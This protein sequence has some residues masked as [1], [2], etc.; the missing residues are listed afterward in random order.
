M[1]PAERR[2]SHATTCR[3]IGSALAGIALAIEPGPALA[4]IYKCVDPKTRAVTMSQTQCPDATLPSAAEVAASAEAARVAKN[5]AEAARTAR[6]AD[7]QSLAHFPDEAAHRR[8][9][10]EEIDAVIRKIR[11]TMR[12]FD[13]LVA[14]RR[15]LDV[16]AA[17]YVGK[18]MPLPL[19]RAIED[20]EG[21]FRGLADIFRGEE[22]SVADIVVRYR[23]EREPLR[24]LWS[25]TK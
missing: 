21:S 24:K 22:K 18:P 1:L 4:R 9:E 13:D 3:L 7:S 19:R 11:F 15:P 25:G 6:L 23:T 2:T 5:D 12:R 20:N 16:Q 14:E 10:A 17:F 8:S